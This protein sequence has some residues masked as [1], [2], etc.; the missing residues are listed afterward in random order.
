MEP[1]PAWAGPAVDGWDRRLGRDM[2]AGHGERRAGGGQERA[3]SSGF[4]AGL[5]RSPLD[6]G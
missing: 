4:W 3:R 1:A 2:L 6:K 5:G